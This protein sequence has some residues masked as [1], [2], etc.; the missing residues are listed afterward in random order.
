MT[1]ELI[2]WSNEFNVGHKVLDYQHR[3]LVSIT[4]D[5]YTGSKKGGIL[6]K[7][8]FWKTLQKAVA[9]VETHFSTEEELMLKMNYPGYAEHKKEHE[10]FIY[11]VTEQIRMFDE[12]DN[13]DHNIFIKYLID[14][15]I[16]HIANSDKKLAPYFGK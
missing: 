15:I 8:Y 13:P 11:N 7:A 14:W 2:S 9:Y 12:T 6:A 10:D 4:N 5:F 1:R 16:Q 3:E